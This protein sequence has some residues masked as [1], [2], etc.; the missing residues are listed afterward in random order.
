MAVVSV[1]SVLSSVAVSMYTS[2]LADVVPTVGRPSVRACVPKPML[3]S[4]VPSCAVAV[5][6]L[7]MLAEISS[8]SPLPARYAKILSVHVLPCETME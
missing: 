6:E 1:A 5:G 3:P 8:H 7:E 2:Q 4:A